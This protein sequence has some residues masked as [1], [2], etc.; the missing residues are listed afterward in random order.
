MTKIEELQ[1]KIKTLK[2]KVQE[3]TK[4]SAET[5]EVNS[6]NSAETAQANMDKSKL[7]EVRALRK[8]LKRAQR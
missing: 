7:A 3:A 6:G 2:T 4:N 1:T 5:P 8:S